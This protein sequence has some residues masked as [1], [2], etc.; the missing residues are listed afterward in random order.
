MQVAE[1]RDVVVTQ[2]QL[3][4]GPLRC[5]G[6]ECHT[7]IAVLHGKPTTLCVTRDAH[8]LTL[9][10]PGLMRFR[11]PLESTAAK[12]YR[13]P[14]GAGP[15]LLELDFSTT[16]AI[17][18]AYEGPEQAHIAFSAEVPI[19]PA[20][21]APYIG[22]YRTAD[23]R[24]LFLGTRGGGDGAIPFILDGDDVV[25]L[26]PT[27]AASFVSERG[28]FV[29]P[30]SDVLAIARAGGQTTIANRFEPYVSLAVTFEA[31]GGA[32]LAGTLF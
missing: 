14:P 21:F 5:V 27:S 26:H 11:L 29:R 10:L 1:G 30:G 2:R 20:T 16:P 7:G 4:A 19:D 9:D 31:A 32:M 12:T 3:L 22:A 13:V 18:V 28:E 25:R 23:G 17:G 15:S 6:M 24:E 8:G